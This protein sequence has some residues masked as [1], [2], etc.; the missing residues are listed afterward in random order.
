MQLSH[1]SISGILETLAATLGP[2]DSSLQKNEP[3]MGRAAAAPGLQWGP[4]NFGV[5]C[6]CIAELCRQLELNF[7]DASLS[8]KS[9][10]LTR[11][12]WILPRPFPQCLTVHANSKPRTFAIRRQAPSAGTT[13]SI[14]P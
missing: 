2:N 13:Q 12:A 1:A 7:G 5:G 9:L 11:Q 14:L 8:Y 3:V 4:V 6:E 10:Y